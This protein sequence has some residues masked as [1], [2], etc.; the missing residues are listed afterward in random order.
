MCCNSYPY[1]LNVATLVIHSS[2]PIPLLQQLHS[3]P[4]SSFPKPLQQLH[5]FHCS[6]LQRCQRI[7][8]STPITLSFSTSLKILL[9][10]IHFNTLIPSCISE[11]TDISPYLSIAAPL[12]PGSTLF[13][14]SYHSDSFLTLLNGI[15]IHKCY[16]TSLM[17]SRLLQ[18]S[19]IYICNNYNTNVI[20]YQAV[21]CNISNYI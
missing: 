8:L 15:Q 14:A 21:C 2:Y 9:R 19:Y 4:H 16:N 6:M 5:V 10:H 20:K 17:Y 3:D 18:Q 1:S 11:N 13:H 7:Y 12:P